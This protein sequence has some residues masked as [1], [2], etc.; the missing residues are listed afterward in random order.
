MKFRTI[1][2]KIELLMTIRKNKFLSYATNK[3]I[4]RKYF[5]CFDSSLSKIFETNNKNHDHNTD[6]IKSN[7]SGLKNQL[8]K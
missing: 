7:K 5:T 2:D 3:T 8:K 6:P 1:S 4:N